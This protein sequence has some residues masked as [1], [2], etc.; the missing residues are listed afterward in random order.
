MLFLEKNSTVRT[1]KLYAAFMSSEVDLGDIHAAPSDE[2]DEKV[3][4][5]YYYLIQEFIEGEVVSEFLDSSGD[6]DSDDD[7]HFIRPAI[8]RK[9]GHLLGEQLQKLRSVQSKSDTFGR[10]NGRPFQHFEPID[11]PEGPNYDHWGP[12]TYEEFVSRVMHTS[13]VHTVQSTNDPFHSLERQMFRDAKSVL[14]DNAG[15]ADRI[16][17]LSHLDL[18]L[19]NVIVKIKYDEGGEALDV[20]HMVIVNWLHMAW[21]PPWFEAGNLFCQGLHGNRMR[22][23]VANIALGDLEQV[24]TAIVCFW[25]YGLREFLRYTH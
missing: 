19:A 16:P 18:D 21:S 22:A 1:P 9:I 14:L 13:K 10:I 2:T 6:D 17:V 25:G 20:E 3:S 15:P 11:R 23:A 5:P 24:N 12:F 7:G 8:I 4:K